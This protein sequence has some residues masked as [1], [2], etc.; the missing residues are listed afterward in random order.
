VN[1]RRDNWRSTGARRI[2]AL[3]LAAIGLCPLSATAQGS[4]KIKDFLGDLFQ[5]EPTGQEVAAGLSQTVLD[6]LRR[7]P[8]ETGKL[9]GLG[10]FSLPIGSSSAG[11]AYSIDPTTGEPTL[12][13]DS[14]GPVF[15]ERPLTS[16]KGVLNLSFNVQHSRFDTLN[17]TRVDDEGQNTRAQG[18]F[19]SDNGGIFPDGLT[20]FITDKAY[21][22]VSATSYLLNLSYGVTDRLDIGVT[23]PIMQVELTGR[24]QRFFDVT[25][26]FAEDA[27]TRA[28]FPEGPVGVRDVITTQSLNATGIGDLVVKAKYGF[29]QS[30]NHG[31]AVTLDARLP[32]GDEEDLLGLGEASLRTM[33]VGAK[34]LGSRASV[35][36]NAGYTVGGLSDE[37]HYI[38][39]IDF[40][41][42]SARKLTLAG[43]V[44]GQTL[45]DGFQIDVLRTFDRVGT[46]GVRTTFDRPLLVDDS[47]HLVNAA[48]GAKYNLGG[49]WLLTA[50]VLFPLND[51]GFRGGPTP[52]IGLDR[53]WTRRAP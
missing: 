49:Q 5:T 9:V 33:L 52:I 36:G 32:T 25:R 10:I 35:Y 24:R 3:T 22:E 43:S 41:V 51:E 20:Q 2:G 12:K 14:F 8:D 47:L 6:N 48:V 30:Q 37:V 1:S 39:G 38:G 46:T 42:G 40:V 53:T 15:A 28:A 34:G 29:V 23:V 4:P 50:S 45:R 7:F 21:V 13:S 44:I 16:G 17:G 26:S 31:L 11:F 18:L 27:E 19:I